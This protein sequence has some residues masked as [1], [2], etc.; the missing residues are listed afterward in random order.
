ML[1]FHVLIGRLRALFRR[2]SVLRDID[3]EMRSHIEIETQ[4][5]IEKG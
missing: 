2:E 1:W 5:Y 4:A 3:E